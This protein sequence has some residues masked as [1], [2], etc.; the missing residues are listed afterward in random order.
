MA[1]VCAG[2]ALGV[3]PSFLLPSDCTA[4]LEP[5]LLEWSVGERGIYAVYPHRRLVPSKVRAFVDF[6]R[7]ELGDGEDDPWWPATVTVPGPKRGHAKAT[8]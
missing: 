7:T 4:R 6:F 8:R 2:V 1:A 5:V 3:I